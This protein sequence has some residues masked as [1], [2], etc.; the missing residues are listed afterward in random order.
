MPWVLDNTDSKTFSRNPLEL[1]VAELR[2][3]TILRIEESKGVPEFQDLVRDEYPLF[4][5]RLSRDL[6]FKP[7]TNELQ[8]RDS[9]QFIFSTDDR[10]MSISLS[11]QSL[12]VESKRYLHHGE[13]LKGVE[14]AINALSKVYS[15]IKPIRLG[16]RYVNKVGT[17]DLAAERKAIEWHDVISEKV[18]PSLDILE[19]GMQTQL[20]TVIRAPVDHGFLTLRI[21]K[22]LGPAEEQRYDIDI[23]RYIEGH[24]EIQDVIPTLRK[25]SEDCYFVFVSTIGPATREWLEREAPD[26]TS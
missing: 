21:G 16:L 14:K 4:D 20:R 12:A 5:E 1:V 10:T 26:A 11:V 15:P 7:G 6:R 17:A 19:L 23:D 8:V 13:F 25:F 2:F 18:L 22:S 9:K 3:N 24:F